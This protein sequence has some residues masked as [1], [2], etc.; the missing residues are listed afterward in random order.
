MKKYK[1]FVTSYKLELNDYVVDTIILSTDDIYHEIG[2]IYCTSLTRI[3][4]ISYFE[5]ERG[6]FDVWLCLWNFDTIC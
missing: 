5:I 2:L 3:K 4:D 1:I 6:V